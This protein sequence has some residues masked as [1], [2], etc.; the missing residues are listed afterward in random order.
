MSVVGS[1]VV[2]GIHV[3]VLGSLVISDMDVGVSMVRLRVIKS[4]HR[5]AI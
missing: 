3:N 5:G 2:S 1:R 4:I